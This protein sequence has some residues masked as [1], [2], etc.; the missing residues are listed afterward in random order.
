[1]K[2]IK[3]DIVYT[4]C[5]GYSRRGPDG[6]TV[7]LWVPSG[8]LYHDKEQLNRAFARFKELADKKKVVAEADIEAVVS[9]EI[10]QPQEVYR[11]EHLQVS[12]GDHAIPTATVCL[13]APSGELI[14]DSAHGTG[15]VDAVYKAINRIVGV[16]NKLTEFSIKAV[17]EGIDAV[18]EVTVRIEA[19]ATEHN[20][21]PIN[22]QT[23]KKTLVFS[24]H[25]ASTDIIVASGRAYM[26]A[27]NK[28]LAIRQSKK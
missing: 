25:G 20:G 22:P 4:N 8:I 2:A 5:Y 9:D 24:G 12:C 21:L 1:M 7:L 27:L 13:R 23:G 15:P 6:D 17:T 26:N 10:F 3:P 28:L 18:G 11:L 19:E 16:P 14:T